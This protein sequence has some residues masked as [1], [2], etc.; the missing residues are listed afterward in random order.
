MSSHVLLCRRM[1]RRVKRQKMRSQSAHLLLQKMQ[2]SQR[3]V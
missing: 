1:C 3:Q 2:L